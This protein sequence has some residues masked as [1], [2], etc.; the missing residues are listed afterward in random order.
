M[1]KTKK[2]HLR[3]N[4]VHVFYY[5]NYEWAQNG[6]IN[7]EEFREKFEAY[8]ENFIKKHNKS[9]G[10]ET[11][12]EI[13]VDY[14]FNIK[15]HQ[16]IERKTGEKVITNIC[17]LSPE[18]LEKDGKKLQKFDE[19]KIYQWKNVKQ[20]RSGKQ[21]N[22]EIEDMVDQLNLTGTPSWA[23][24]LLGYHGRP[25]QFEDIFRAWY[26]NEWKEIN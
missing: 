6:Q 11:S 9:G 3:M 12:P 24:L 22:K 18:K 21:V 20:I 10:L 23:I 8:R 15:K 7:F 4:F 5:E 26:V 1:K 2:Y 13:M 19:N 16:V 14:L 17:T 25:Y